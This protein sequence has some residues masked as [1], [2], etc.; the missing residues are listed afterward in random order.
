MS[1]TPAAAKA[2]AG[3]FHG[4]PGRVVAK[5]DFEVPSA[6]VYMGEGVAVEYRSDKKVGGRSVGSRVYRHKFGRGVK[7]Y[8]DPKGRTIFVFGGRLVVTDW[9]RY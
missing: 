8:C 1:N 4:R 2:R 5:T 3:K 7:I 9:I 6:L